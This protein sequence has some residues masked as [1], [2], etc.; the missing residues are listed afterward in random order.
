VSISKAGPGL[1]LPPSA[2]GAAQVAAVGGVDNQHLV[3]ALQLL[4]ETGVDRL[5][6]G[7]APLGL[8]AA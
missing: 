1:L 6:V 8:V 5:S 7:A 4:L 2:S 3:A